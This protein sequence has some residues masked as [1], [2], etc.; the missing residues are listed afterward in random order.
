VGEDPDRIRREIEATRAEMG[1]TVDALGYKADVKSRAREKM[2]QTKDKL[3]G[4]VSSAAPERDDVG[5]KAR[6]AAGIAQE[7]PLGLA[8][9]SVAVGFVAGLLIP[10]TRVEDEK[11]GEASDQ[12]VEKAKETGQEALEHGKQVAQEAA[13]SAQETMKE[14][15]QE[16]AQQVKDSAQE[17]AQDVKQ[18]AQGQTSSSGSPAMSTYRTH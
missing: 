15:G 1:D 8:I 17:S 11:L 12:V 4:R 14:S 6:Q 5:R 7:N 9:G 10:S 18:E 16:R 3:T 2:T 13:Q